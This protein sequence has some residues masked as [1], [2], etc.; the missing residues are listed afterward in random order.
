M[1]HAVFY[2]DLNLIFVHQRKCAGLS[3]RSA[4]GH[5]PEDLNRM[6]QDGVLSPE[7]GD[8]VGQ[9]IKVAVIRNPW[10]RFVSGWRYCRSTKERSLPN[11]LSDPPSS[12]H[13]YRHVTRQQTAT[14]FTQDGQ[15]AVDFVLRFETLQADFAALCQILSIPRRP[16]P[17]KNKGSGDVSYT[18]L[19]GPRQQELFA[20]RFRDDVRMLGYSFDRPGH[21]PD[22]SFIGER[23]FLDESVLAFSSAAEKSSDMKSGS[24]P[25]ASVASQLVRKLGLNVGR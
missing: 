20:N 19:F 9:Y 12:G 10:D 25:F 3:I 11:T 5:L 17:H 18:E 15:L 16:L 1:E 2:K 14:L 4:L 21:P 13:D 6:Y 23:H 22:T 8:D 24:N 7:W